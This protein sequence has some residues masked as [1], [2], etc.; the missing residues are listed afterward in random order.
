MEEVAQ[1]LGIQPQTQRARDR[2]GKIRVVGTPGDTHLEGDRGA[3]GMS[4][5][6]ER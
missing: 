3:C 5:E 6:A 4:L 1:L 2:Q